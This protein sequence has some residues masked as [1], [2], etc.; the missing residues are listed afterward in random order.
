MKR[1][2]VLTTYI[3][4]IISSL[5]AQN[6][7]KF[8]ESQKQ[9]FE[10]QFIDKSRSISTLQSAF[11]QTKTSTMVSQS[12]VSNGNMYYRNPSMLIWEYTS[13]SKSSLIVDG[14]STRLLDENG[15][16]VGNKNVSKQLG[17]LIINM[18]NGN[19]IVDNKLFTTEIFEIANNQILVVL[20]PQQR[21]LKDFYSTIKI[22]VDR[23]TLIATEISMDEKSGDNTVV[24]FTNIQ[25]N[26]DI[27]T[28]KFKIK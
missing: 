17:S 10:K 12:A 6:T 27:P 20:T 4:L 26:K 8:T 13:P 24:S 22:K 11:V 25:L 7:R 21:R 3:L 23:N 5:Q 1:T 18:I 14:R 19:S 28:S 16:I 9:A 2:L 15:N